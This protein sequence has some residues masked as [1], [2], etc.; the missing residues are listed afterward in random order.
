MKRVWLVFFSV[1]FAFSLASCSRK[2]KTSCVYGSEIPADILGR[3]SQ[4]GSDITVAFEQDRFDDIYAYSSELLKKVQGP[5]QFKMLSA[6]M[7]SNL[8]PLSFSKL[9]EAYYLRNKAG[10]KYDSVMVPCNLGAENV[11]DIYQVPPNSEVVS[12]IYGVMAGKERAIIFIELI[13]EGSD[14]KLIS[15]VPSPATV[16]GKNVDGYIQ[17]ARKAREA[18]KFRLAIVYYDMAYLLSD[19]SPNV[20]EFVAQKTMEEMSQ[21]KADYVPTGESQIWNITAETTPEVYNVDV[22]FLKGQPWVNIDWLTENFDDKPKLDATSAKILEFAFQRFPE[23]REFFTGIMVTAHS[24][25]PRLINEVY[26][27]TRQFPATAK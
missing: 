23:Y 6:A 2:P 13:K 1:L 24:P 25:D 3:V 27:K 16:Q 21:V 18:G 20:M 19:L 5:E 7:K 12:L 9:D 11:N 14:W 4:I 26:R 17:L 8:G 22:F 15:L 10:K